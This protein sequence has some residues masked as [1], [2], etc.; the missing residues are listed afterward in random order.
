MTAL[1]GVVS[2]A[3][4]AGSGL[5]VC[6]GGAGE[7]TAATQVANSTTTAAMNRDISNFQTN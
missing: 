6:G 3:H 5:V 2:M 4:A 1:I 7:L